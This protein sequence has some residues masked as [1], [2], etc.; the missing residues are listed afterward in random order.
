MAIHKFQF[1]GSLQQTTLGLLSH[2]EPF[3]TIRAM[4]GLKVFSGP[5]LAIFAFMSNFASLDIC[6]LKV[7]K[8]LGPE[9]FWFFVSPEDIEAEEQM[10]RQ[11]SHQMHPS[12][13]SNILLKIVKHFVNCQ[14]C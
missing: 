11:P 6:V 9:H 13:L 12:I 4:L 5:F 10:G 2:I 8:N 7:S 3:W 14:V 1:S